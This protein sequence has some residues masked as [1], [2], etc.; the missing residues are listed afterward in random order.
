M[1]CRPRGNSLCRPIL[2]PPSPALMTST[3]TTWRCRWWPS[4]N[5]S[6]RATTPSSTLRSMPTSG[7][8]MRMRTKRKW[9]R[10][11]QVRIK[12][13]KWIPPTIG[14][15]RHHRQ[16][17][18]SPHP[19]KF[20]VK[21]KGLRSFP[22]TLQIPRN[23]INGFCFSNQSI[24]ATPTVAE[25]LHHLRFPCSPSQ[26]RF[27]RVILRSGQQV[28]KM[29]LPITS[30]LQRPLRNVLLLRQLHSRSNNN[31]PHIFSILAL[32]YRILIGTCNY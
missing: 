20:R 27:S 21:V 3:G 7:S 6:W 29:K 5:S 30:N 9:R 16:C 25:L 31:P 24:A 10:T 32:L 18:W 12:V 19:Q 23:K 2:T 22:K 14:D 26:C 13:S 17:K 28:K 4:G 11:L 1:V 8:T 15:H